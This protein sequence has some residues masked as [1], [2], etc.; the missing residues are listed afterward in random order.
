MIANLV[1]SEESSKKKRVLFFGRYKCDFSKK[2]YKYLKNIGFDV[3]K[4]ISKNRNESLLDDIEWWAGEYIICFRSHF[5]LNKSLLNKASIAAI[6]F[7]P[8]PVEYPGSGCANWALYNEEKKYGVTAHIMNEKV[9]NGTI[10][11]C[12]RFS[13]NSNDTIK[14]LL[15]KTH[16]KAFDLL[17]D[18]VKGLASDDKSFLRKK[19]EA[20]KAEKWRGEARK[21]AEIDQLQTVN[22]TF[23]KKDLERIIKA[24]HTPNF[25]L[26]IKLHG[27]EFILKL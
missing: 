12:R 26:K 23:K 16:K 15:E 8:A 14:T 10:I 11:E 1:D 3:T 9:D 19:I 25:P 4:V 5:I 20:S 6:N 27:Y 2:T 21:I 13:I 7:H 18:I 17:C 24:T 22:T